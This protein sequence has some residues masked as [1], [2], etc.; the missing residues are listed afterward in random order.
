MNLLKPTVQ[1][2]HALSSP[3]GE[4]I[5]LVSRTSFILPTSFFDYYLTR[6]LFRQQKQS[7][8]ELMSSLQYVSQLSSLVRSLT[9]AF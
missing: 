4:S 1:V 3:L 5:S 6:Y 2:L 9:L 7:L 8:S